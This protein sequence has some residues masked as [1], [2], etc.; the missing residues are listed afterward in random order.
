[1]DGNLL[2]GTLF[3]LSR[4]SLEGP[5]LRPCPGCLKRAFHDSFWECAELRTTFRDSTGKGSLL[6]TLEPPTVKSVL[7][8]GGVSQWALPSAP[9]TLGCSTLKAGGWFH[10]QASGIMGLRAETGSWLQGAQGFT[11]RR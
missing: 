1:M 3:S 11:R 5:D 8:G 10:G 6:A 7:G 4:L 2:W 9:D